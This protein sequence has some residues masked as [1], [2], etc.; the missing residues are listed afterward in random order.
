GWHVPSNIEWFD[1]IYYLGGTQIAGGKMKEVGTLNWTTPNANAT[2]SSL[3]SALPSGSRSSFASFNSINSSASFW[4]SS[5]DGS[6][7]AYYKFLGY[8]NGFLFENTTS[9][10]SG[11]SIRCIKD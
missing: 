2:N 7:D 11:I 4:S 1:L 9:K 3:F 5:E 10:K 8:N 6:L